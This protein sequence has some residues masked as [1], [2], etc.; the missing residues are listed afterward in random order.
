[1]SDDFHKTIT[2]VLKKKKC[3]LKLHS[4]GL[5]QQSMGAAP[6]PKFNRSLASFPDICLYFFL[7]NFTRQEEKVFTHN[8]VYFHAVSYPLGWPPKSPSWF[9]LGPSIQ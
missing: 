5:Y 3:K 1:M 2:A 6:V 7:G 9:D 4:I 8:T